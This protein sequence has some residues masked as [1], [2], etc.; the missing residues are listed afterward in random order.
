MARLLRLKSLCLL[1]RTLLCKKVCF[2]VIACSHTL[3]KG[4]FQTSDL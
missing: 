2:L 3:S 1:Q 4:C